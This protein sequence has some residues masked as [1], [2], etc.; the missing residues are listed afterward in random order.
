MD[1]YTI[2]DISKAK[3]YPKLEFPREISIVNFITTLK[4]DVSESIDVIDR[5]KF[6][7]DLTTMT[8]NIQKLKSL[9]FHMSIKGQEIIVKKDTGID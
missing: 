7:N 6:I 2:L 3:N 9:S 1:L 5:L 8:E 4:G